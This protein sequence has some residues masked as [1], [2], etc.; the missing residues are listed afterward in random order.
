MG[1]FHEKIEKNGMRAQCFWGSGRIFEK[2]E[3][4]SIVF[5]KN[6]RYFWQY[7]GMRTVYFSWKI[8]KKRHPFDFFGPKY[9]LVLAELTFFWTKY[10]HDN[11][12]FSCKIWKKFTSEHSVL[13]RIDVCMTKHAHES[14]LFLENGRFSIKHGHE[15]IFFSW[16]WKN[17]HPI[18]F[19][20]P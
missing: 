3:R 15:S 14:S 12:S 18:D 7:K 20:G 17:G 10:G 6:G 19:L 16:N 5:L 11:R 1:D 2:Y 4:E 9:S 8:E 13:E